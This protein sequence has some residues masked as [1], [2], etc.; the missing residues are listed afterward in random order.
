MARRVRWWFLN[1]PKVV[2]IEG[3]PRRYGNSTKLAF[4]AEKGA[5]DMGCLTEI[6]WISDYEIKPCIGCVSDDIMAC[7][8][9][10]VIRDDFNKI[11]EKLIS[12]D[13]IILSTPIYWYMVP[14]HVKILLDR[15]TSLENMLL[16]NGKSLLDGKVAAFI[17]TGNDAGTSTTIS[18]LMDVFNSYGCHIPAW[19]LAYHHSYEDVLNNGPAVIDSYNIGINVCR[20]SK[21][22]KEERDPWYTFNVDFDELRKYTESEI[23]KLKMSPLE[24]RVARANGGK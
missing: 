24:E 12:S 4:I 6:I 1:T 17:A 10:C 14:G 19:A 11:A 16:H 5:K 18:Y 22:L 2:I 9:P 20:L 23:S 8:Y 13:G 21:V 3:S 7:K 15:M